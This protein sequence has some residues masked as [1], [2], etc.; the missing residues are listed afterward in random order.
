[1]SIERITDGDQAI[2]PEIVGVTNRSGDLSRDRPANRS[3]FAIGCRI[4]RITARFCEMPDAPVV[5]T[6]NISD[7]LLIGSTGIAVV[8]VDIGIDT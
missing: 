1:M 5:V 3:V 7:V 8:Q 2:G 4:K 6:P